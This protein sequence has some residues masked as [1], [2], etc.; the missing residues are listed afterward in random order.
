MNMNELTHNSFA[1]NSPDQDVKLQD[2]HF[3]SKTAN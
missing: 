2:F 3:W 1:A